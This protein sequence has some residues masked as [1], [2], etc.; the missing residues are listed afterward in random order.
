MRTLYRLGGA[1]VHVLVGAIDRMRVSAEGDARYAHDSVGEHAFTDED[2]VW[3]SD[4]R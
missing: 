3:D 2:F 4:E 1:L